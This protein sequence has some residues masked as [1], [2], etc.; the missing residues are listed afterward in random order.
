METALMIILPI[1]TA[2]CTVAA[3]LIARAKEHN[4]SGKQT[5][6]IQ[7]DI[8]HIKRRLDDLLLEIRDINKRVEQYGERITRIEESAK[9]AH[10]RLDD[11]E[12]R[13]KAG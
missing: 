9:A 11:I 8:D 13:R 1:V 3:F 10:K 7:A 4:T 5:G 12:K 6:M 2:G